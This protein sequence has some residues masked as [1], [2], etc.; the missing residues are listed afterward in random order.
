MAI[1]LGLIVYVGVGINNEQY[2]CDSIRDS[3][4][5]LGDVAL[6][7]TPALKTRGRGK[8]PMPS[9]RSLKDSSP[10]RRRCWR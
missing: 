9:A 3:P 8:I 5:L 6:N 1:A 10:I 2:L 4:L 7:Y